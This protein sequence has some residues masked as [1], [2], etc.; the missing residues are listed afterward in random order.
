MRIQ[1]AR[2]APLIAILVA[3]FWPPG[4][5]AQTLVYEREFSLIA[6]ADNTLRITLTADDRIVIERPKFM[7]RS[8][9]HKA[10]A[11]AGSYAQL[12]QKLNGIAP[13]TRSVEADIRRRAANERVH[14]SDPEFTRF[15]ALDDQRRV[16][17][18]VE[19]TSIGA[20]NRVFEDDVRLANLASLERDWME[21]MKSAMAGG[22]E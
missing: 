15:M 10:R 11:P 2:Y 13:I 21:L 3:A 6:D 18:A 7:T 12:A 1:A 16:V 9:R 22:A 5:P 4:L 8:G 19:A 14:V 20:W 17:D